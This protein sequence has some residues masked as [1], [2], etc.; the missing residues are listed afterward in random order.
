MTSAVLTDAI[1]QTGAGEPYREHHDD[2][3]VHHPNRR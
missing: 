2:H 1:R 3:T